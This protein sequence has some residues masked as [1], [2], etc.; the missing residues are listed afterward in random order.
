MHD[1]PST[2][3]RKRRWKVRLSAVLGAFA[4]AAS[5][6]VVPASSPAFASGPLRE[7]A[8]ARNKFIGAA[9]ATGPLSGEAQYRTIAGTEFNQVTAENAMKWDAT[10]PNDDQLNFSGADQIV[11]FATQNGQQ[12]HGHTLVWHSQTPG[13][14]QGLSATAMRAEMQEHINAVAGRY[15]NNAAVVSWDVVNEA[16]NEDGT[17]RASFWQNTMGNGY[18]ADAFNFARAADPNAQLCIN[19]F[20]VEGINAKS[21]AMFNLVQQLRSQGVPITCVGFQGHLAIQFGFPNDIQQNLQRFAN[22]GVQVRITELDI[23]MQLPRDA[24]KDATQATQYRNV[25]TACNNVTACAGVT[26][27]GFTDRHS[28]VPGT[29][30]G[31]GAALIYDENYQQKPAYTAVHDALAGGTSTDT[32]P[33][34]TPGAPTASSVTSNSASLSWGASTDSG[35]SGLAGY[36]IY[37]EQGATDPLLSQTTGTGTTTNLTALTPSTQYQVYVRARDGAGNLSGNST[38]VTF[39][40]QQGQTGGTCAVSATAQNQ[41]GTGYVMQVTV[42]NNGTGTSNGWSVPAALPSGHTLVNAWNASLTG[43]VATN[44]SYNGRLGPGQSTSWGFQANRPSGNTQLPTIN[45]CTLS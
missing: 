22:L 14:V 4:L 30:Q 2:P 34:S 15:A 6:L 19:D 20:N 41:W 37:R 38:A 45:S 42:T 16:F 18:I 40:T 27:W 36:N 1:T 43:G 7:H 3:A 26:I 8:A 21:T 39:T 33:P 29:F 13:Y 35:G 24:S 25:V 23:R 31:E 44:A 9:L 28:W 5:F 32:T 10:E 12:V 17:R 11:N